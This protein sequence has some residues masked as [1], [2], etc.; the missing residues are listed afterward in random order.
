MSLRG[1]MGLYSVVPVTALLLAMG[2]ADSEMGDGP[3]DGYVRFEAPPVTVQPGESGMWLH[4]VADPVDHDRN[5]DDLIGSQGL[6]GHHAILY[7]TTELQ[8]VGTTRDFGNEDQGN[9][10]FVG[11][12]GG[13]GAE[14]VKLPPGVVFRV[15][16]GRALVIQSHYLNT[17]DAPFEG[18]STIDVRF[19]EPSDQDLVASFFANAVRTIDVPPHQESQQ[20]T[21]CVLQKDLPLI[22]YANHMHE[23][24]AAVTTSILGSDSEEILKQDEVWNTEWTFNPDYTHASPEAPLLLTVGSTLKTHCVW[25]N[26]TDRSL[27]SPDEMCVFFAFFLGEKDITCADG[28][29]VE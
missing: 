17:S 16:A 21:A 1:R 9:L 7:T 5:I 18:H 8:P 2:C 28:Y 6:G 27:T 10:H 14:S 24:G 12:T 11:G 25:N 23:M 22:M 29:W 19:S 13:E 4:W 15:P 20:E 26:T 3:P